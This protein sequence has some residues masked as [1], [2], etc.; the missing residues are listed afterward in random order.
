MKKDS[1]YKFFFKALIM[2][3]VIDLSMMLIA[4]GLME[5]AFSSKYGNELVYEIFY[6][7]VVL[8]VL[9]LF[10]NSYIF[11]NKKEKMGKGIILAIPLLAFSIISLIQ[12]IGYI[13]EFSFPIFINIIV[14]SICVGVTEEFLCRGWIQN[15]FI[16]RYS[17]DK[18]SVLL[19][20][21]LS[22]LIFGFMHIVNALGNQGLFETLLQI[23]NA[24]SIGF[25]FGCIYYKTK[26]IWT[27]IFLH[28]F[29]D[30][31][32]LL[33]DMNTIKDCT[34]SVPT[35][36]TSITDFISI[37]ILIGI[38]LLTS[39]L[40]I[41]K[42]NYPDK[43]ASRKSKSYK[44]YA[45]AGIIG[46]LLLSM[47][48]FN[49][50]IP[51]YVDNVT[52]YMYKEADSIDY[53]TVHYPSKR[54]Y[55]ITYSREDPMYVVDNND[56]VSLSSSI[57]NFDLE[58]KIDSNRLIVKN[59]KTKYT[60]KFDFKKI[61]D[62]EILHNED[63]FTIVLLSNENDDTVYYSNY[64]NYNNL[65]NDNSYIDEIENSFKEFALPKINNLGYIT[66]DDTQYKYP[67]FLSDSDEKFIIKNDGIFIINKEK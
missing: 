61:V 43:K 18:K 21:L 17:N 11:T 41:D 59:N 30:F 26:N 56:V 38:W 50:I 20:I 33:S 34:Y 27:V 7:I 3:V 19:S 35:F 63:E 23:M 60:K 47:I 4:S 42:T 16:E 51:G 46:L 49:E 44:K 9:L 67:L 37:S 28:S 32:L 6:G 57:N 62:L 53:Y 29:Y 64:I 13:E 55:Y 15:E 14:F 40:I 10:N 25:L 65:S 52:C 1:I 36:I 12:S 2:F 58:F 31:T 8:I 5:S 24:T 54:D 45:I 22:S 66:I 39:L 48:S